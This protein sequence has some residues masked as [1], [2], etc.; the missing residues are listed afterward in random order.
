QVLDGNLPR[1]LNCRP[2]Q[3]HLLSPSRPCTIQQPST[4]PSNMMARRANS[5]A[6][7]NGL[8]SGTLKK[9]PNGRRQWTRGSNSNPRVYSAR[10]AVLL[11]CFTVLPGTF[12]SSQTTT[13]QHVGRLPTSLH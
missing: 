2:G 4:L 6:T 8:H 9:K 7:L 5:H 10:I 1:V 3:F 11:L 13:V 12:L